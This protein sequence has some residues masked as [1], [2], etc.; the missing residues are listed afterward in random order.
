MSGRE[1][2][3][4]KSWFNNFISEFRRRY[5]DLPESTR[6][7][8]WNIEDFSTPCQLISIVLAGRE[9]TYLW[10]RRD[11]EIPDMDIRCF[12]P[13][14]PNEF[15][16]ISEEILSD[17]NLYKT[18]KDKEAQN[19][20]EQSF[21][22]FLERQLIWA[23]K[24][25][26]NLPL[27]KVDFPVDHV[28]GMKNAIPQNGFFWMVYGDI[29][30]IDVE[31]I[32]KE[33]FEGAFAREKSQKTNIVRASETTKKEEE[34]LSGY[35]TYFFP[36]V[37]IGEIPVFDFRSK[38]NGIFI[39]PIPTYLMEYKNYKLVFNQKG[40]FFLGIKDR[41]KCIKYMNEIIGTAILQGYN[42]DI[43]TDLDI[44]ES[45]VT[46]EKVEMRS[47]TY[48]ISI[49]RNWQFEQWMTPITEDM[50]ASYIQVK[51]EDMRNIV[52]IAESASIDVE[53][54]DYLVFFAHAS[55]YV[56]DG[57]YKESFLFDWFV[58]ERY[59]RNKWDLYIGVNSLQ[60]DKKKKLRYWDT[61]NVIEVLY[62][63]GKID[64]KIYQD[65]SSLKKIRNGFYHKGSEVSKEDAS[66]C[67]KIS[68][69]LI[70]K[71]TN[72]VIPEK[73]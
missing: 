55:N 46:K 23:L 7:F 71:E 9:L 11:H 17:K 49:T 15:I 62:L 1:N 22:N 36:P 56:R 48:A 68:E 37:W 29:T 44:G 67:H 13:I 34:L 60:E 25:V 54:S 19:W 21:G 70:R 59:L 38:V 12:G 39:F 2:L 8:V 51:E 72:I 63:T 57:K 69:I 64:Q 73:N 53:I 32:F 43:V 50:I 10:V 33:I 66:R 45:T 6:K 16:E 42:L 40:L 35:S 61:N 5:N 27:I 18:V 24:M 20:Q 3:D 41:G 26:Q 28:I 52:K 14:N 4:C 30:K 58:I 31:L 47:K 65:I